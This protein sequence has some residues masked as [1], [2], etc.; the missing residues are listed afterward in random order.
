MKGV[1][2]F[3]IKDR[4][5]AVFTEFFKALSV[6]EYLSGRKSISSKTCLKVF[7]VD[8]LCTISSAWVG[9]DNLQK[10]SN[11][12]WYNRKKGCHSERHG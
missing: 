5:A 7:N 8:T 11:G 2:I 9:A 4:Y 12:L 10:Q 3:C 1:F 6:R